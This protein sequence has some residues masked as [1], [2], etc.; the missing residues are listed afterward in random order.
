MHGVQNR[1]NRPSEASEASDQYPFDPS[2]PVPPL[3]N[4]DFRKKLGELITSV[5]LG[6]WGRMLA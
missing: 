1:A 2:E 4:E 5:Q 6:R 3:D